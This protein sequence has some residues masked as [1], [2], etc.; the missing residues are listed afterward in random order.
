MRE[1]PQQRIDAEMKQRVR[2][3]RYNYRQEQCVA[4]IG[5]RARHNPAKR[6]VK[7]IADRND[8]LHESGAAASREQGQ[9][10]AHSEE[11]VNYP[12]DVIDDL[13]NSR[14][15]SR[16]L[17]FALS[18]NNLVNSFRTKLAGH[19][20]DLLCLAGRSFRSSACADLGLDVAFNLALY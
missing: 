19:L 11:R 5:A 13:G 4:G 1:H 18:V 8:E 14:Q 16:A 20:I 17:D 9:E 3:Y 7:R 6:S 10:K 12:E 2:D 15:G